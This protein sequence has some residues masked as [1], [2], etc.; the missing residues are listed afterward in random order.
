MTITLCDRCDTE[1]ASYCWRHKIDECSDCARNCV[2][3]GTGA[4]R[5]LA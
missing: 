2:A 3:G 4:L 1:G 5:G